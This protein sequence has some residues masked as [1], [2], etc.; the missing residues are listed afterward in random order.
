MPV[1]GRILERSVT[2][3]ITRSAVLSKDA[4]HIKSSFAFDIGEYPP[5]MLEVC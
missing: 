5:A 1:L 4:V 3:G 2:K